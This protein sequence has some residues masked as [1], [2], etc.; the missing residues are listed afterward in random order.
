METVLGEVDLIFPRPKKNRLNADEKEA[1][2]DAREGE[3]V[4]ENHSL[5]VHHHQADEEKAENGNIDG[6]PSPIRKIFITHSEIESDRQQKAFCRDQKD[7][8]NSQFD[9]RIA[10]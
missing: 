4:G 5:P 1:D 7:Q 3:G 2:R 6:A 8:A 10:K 9:R